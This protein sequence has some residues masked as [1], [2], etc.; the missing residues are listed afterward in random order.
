VMALGG[1]AF[2]ILARQGHAYV[3]PFEVT[4]PYGTGRM[5]VV[6]VLVRSVCVLTAL[7]AVGLSVWAPGALLAAGEIFGDPLQ[8][9]QRTIEGAGGALTGYQQLALAV[10]GGIGVAM[11]VASRAALAALWTRYP[12]R[13]NIAGSLLLLYG[14]ALVALT[15]AAQRWNVPLG[16]IFRATS[17]IAAAA[18]VSVTV[19]LAWRTFVERLL[20]R[21]QAWGIVVLSAVFAAAWLTLL[22]AA[23]MSVN[24]M[25]AADAVRILAPA[26]L[27][28]TIGVLAPWSYSR[29]RHI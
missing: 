7:A 21:Y 5:A 9:A 23:G 17:W 27:P 26:L 3:S 29:V 10:L 14:G 12:R 18:I 28:I 8:S 16:V 24:G 2:G 4:Q 11:M 1:N 20:T 13:L 15:L 25:S 6:R 19:Y 22:R